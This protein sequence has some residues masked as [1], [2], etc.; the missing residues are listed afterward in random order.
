MRMSRR[1]EKEENERAFF[2][3][4]TL[5][6]SIFAFYRCIHIF[7]YSLVVVMSNVNFLSNE[8]LV[9]LRESYKIK[10]YLNVNNNAATTSSKKICSLQL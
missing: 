9:G 5:D 6:K 10:L 2:N 1:K 3:S 4:K 7:S 8:L